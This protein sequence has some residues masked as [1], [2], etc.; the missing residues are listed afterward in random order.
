MRRPV[1]AGSDELLPPT[2]R[3]MTPTTTPAPPT[4]NP[5]VEIRPV[6]AVESRSACEGGGQRPSRHVACKVLA[7]ESVKRPA[8]VPT[9]RPT[10]AVPKPMYTSE[11]VFR[12]GSSYGGVV[13]PAAGGGG[14]LGSAAGTSI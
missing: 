1:R 6:V 7:V 12:E 2:S 3:P 9:P 11:L 10:I 8:T 14:A 5:I 13:S 4:A